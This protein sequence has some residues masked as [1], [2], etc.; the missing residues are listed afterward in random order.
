[1]AASLVVPTEHIVDQVGMLLHLLMQDHRRG[2][3]IAQGQHPCIDAIAAAIAPHH[4]LHPAQR[5]ALWAHPVQQHLR[6]MDM[7]MRALEHRPTS[8]TTGYILALHGGT[9]GTVVFGHTAMGV[10]TESIS[11]HTR[12]ALD[13]RLHRWKHTHPGRDWDSVFAALPTG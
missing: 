13:A 3:T 4:R 10:V 7:E 1:M 12:L 2:V 9:L 8:F 11:A 5:V 6:Y